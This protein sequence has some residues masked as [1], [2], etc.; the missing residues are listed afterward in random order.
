MQYEYD[1]NVA[2]YELKQ[3]LAA[4]SADGDGGGGIGPALIFRNIQNLI[5]CYNVWR[6]KVEGLTEKVRVLPSLRVDQGKMDNAK[7]MK[8]LCSVQTS[9]V[10]VKEGDELTLT[11]TTQPNRFKVRTAQGHEGFI[12]ALC[13]LLPAPDRNAATTVERLRVQL[14]VSWTETVRKIQTIVKDCVVTSVRTLSDDW[15]NHLTSDGSWDGRDRVTRRLRRIVNIADVRTGRVDLTRLHD[16]LYSVENELSSMTLNGGFNLG[17]MTETVANLDKAVLCY[18]MFRTHWHQYRKLMARGPRPIRV[19][20]HISSLR[21]SRNG[22]N[23]K[24]YELKMTME[25]SET[26]E[27][28]VRVTR[29]GEVILTTTRTTSDCTSQNETV[30]ADQITQVCAEESKKFVIRAVLDPRTDREISFQDAIARGIVD[31]ERG[32]YVNTVTGEGVPIPQAMNA[33]LILVDYCTTSKSQEKKKAV[34]IITV[35]TAIDRRKFTVRLVTDAVTTDRVDLAEARKRGIVDEDETTF[36]VTTTGEQMD[37]RTA[38]QIGW[39]QVD[40]EDDEEEL[41][42]EEKTYAVNAVVDQRRKI[43]IPF[44]EAVS[45]GLIDRHTAN[46]VNNVTGER[47][48]VTEAIRRGFLK[49]RLVEDTTGLDI[50]GENNIVV[51]AV[52]KIRKNVMGSMGVLSALK[53]AA[54][55]N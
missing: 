38:A 15:R 40:Y 23:I 12:P 10:N 22:M 9:Q 3:S 45:R 33:G 14:L 19:V 42:I 48:Y 32:L 8:A 55:H 25:R 26:V 20:E 35:R 17:D 28:S 2:T 46:Y 7:T 54:N 24:Y 30:S 43:K 27:D 18:Q 13:C 53:K 4:N 5:K 41:E 31:P 51:Q 1:M 6:S 52:A 49:A 47:V 39:I 29:S 36:T 44:L 50:D 34:G 11:D 37:L 16:A 21:P